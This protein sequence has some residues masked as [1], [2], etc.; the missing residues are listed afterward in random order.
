[1]Y[2]TQDNKS[3]EFNFNCEINSSVF[4]TPIKSETDDCTINEMP[5]HRYQNRNN[6]FVSYD[7]P[8]PSDLLLPIL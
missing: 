7:E 6:T 8:I 2:S 4:L 1:M 3:T 5:L